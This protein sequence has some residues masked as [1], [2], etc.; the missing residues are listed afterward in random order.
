MRFD[1]S[2]LRGRI[3]ECYGTSEAFAKEIGMS[4][5][6][7]SQK[8]NNKVCW[9]QEDIENARAALGLSVAELNK[10]FFTKEV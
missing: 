4:R 2:A 10:Y 6:S 3:V 8:L 7:L 9:R 5:S 1:Y